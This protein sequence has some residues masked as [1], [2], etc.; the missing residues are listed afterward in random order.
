MPIYDYYSDATDEYKEVLHGIDE[1]PEVLDSEGNPMKRV[2]L[3][4]HGGDIIKGG[5][6]NRTIRQKL[7]HKKTEN[8]PTPTESAQAKASESARKAEL[9]K[10]SK[11]DPKNPY[12]QFK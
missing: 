11:F 8:M 2:F 1:E 6:R 4:G 10:K 9:D 5:T 12:S 3:P 7:G